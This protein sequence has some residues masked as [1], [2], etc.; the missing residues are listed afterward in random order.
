MK[1]STEQKP[2]CIMR[3]L[4][5]FSFSTFQNVFIFIVESVC[6]CH[7]IANAFSILDQFANIDNECVM[8]MLKYENSK[9]H[10]NNSF[11]LYITFVAVELLCKRLS[12]KNISTKQY[13]HCTK[14]ANSIDSFPTFQVL[15][16]FQHLVYAYVER[17]VEF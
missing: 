13:G 15:S 4:K 6:F 7:V 14:K 11:L 1:P 17:S 8:L 9:E 5:R 3:W 16:H 2:K 10:K 12:L